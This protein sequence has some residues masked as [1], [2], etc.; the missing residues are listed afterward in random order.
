MANREIATLE[1]CV[2][3]PDI[4]AEHWEFLLDCVA[5]E[6]ESTL[7]AATEALENCGQLALDAMPKLRSLFSDAVFV[8]LGPQRQYWLCTL[9]GRYG[10]RAS[11][12]QEWVAQAA[13]NPSLA[14]SVRERAAWCLGELGPLSTQAQAVLSVQATDASERLKRLLQRAIHNDGTNG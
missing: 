8:E 3:Q 9:L 1:K 4:A 7:E 13:S 12:F 10:T 14:L 6:D 2:E 5:S 11:E